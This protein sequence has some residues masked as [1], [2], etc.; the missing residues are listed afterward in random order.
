MT[1]SIKLN[2]TKKLARSLGDPLL[3]RINWNAVLAT[4]SVF[5]VPTCIDKILISLLN[6]SFALLQLTRFS[7][8]GHLFGSFQWAKFLENHEITKK[9]VQV[10]SE[11]R[12]S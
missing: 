1:L 7:F 8:A 9:E 6:T 4:K 11:T 10:G 2:I 3:E 12:F 5:E